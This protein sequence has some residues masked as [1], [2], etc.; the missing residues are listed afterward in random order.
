MNNV[1]FFLL[2]IVFSICAEAIKSAARNSTEESGV[3]KNLWRLSRTRLLLTFYEF[4]EKF[5]Y[6]AFDGC[7]IAL[8]ITPKVYYYL[9]LLLPLKRI[10]LI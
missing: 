10:E 3:E 1:D 7:S 6:N 9:P 8:P 2:L 5:M 4:L